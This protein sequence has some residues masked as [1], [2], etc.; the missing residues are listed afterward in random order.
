MKN[1]AYRRF[2][3]GFFII[4]VLF[5]AFSCEEEKEESIEVK[6]NLPVITMGIPDTLLFEITSSTY[7]LS[8]RLYDTADTYLDINTRA[9]GTKTSQFQLNVIYDPATP[10]DKHFSLFVENI[11]ENKTFDFIVKVIP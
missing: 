6:M 3:V 9:F 11:S 7:L 1:I 10:G 4:I 5:I 2:L 8:A